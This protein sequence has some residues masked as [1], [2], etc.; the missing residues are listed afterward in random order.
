MR[1][2]RRLLCLV[3]FLA[4]ATLA[5]PAQTPHGPPPAHGLTLAAPGWDVRDSA[6][7]STISFGG[8]G[9]GR[10]RGSSH[11]RADYQPH[12]R[13]A[14]A[15]AYASA[16]PRP[17]P[18]AKRWPRAFRH[19]SVTLTNGGAKT[20]ESVRMDF[21]FKD[22]ATGAEVNR[23][24]HRSRKRLRPGETA[25]TRK[26]VMASARHRRGDGMALNVEVTEVVYA[27]GTAW[28]P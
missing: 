17:A 15:N 14:L 9:G 4:A 3:A 13:Q 16:Y 27:D 12:M 2:M 22:P 8:G 23:I 5:A 11:S 20:V 26:E 6:S 25:T 19:A 10:W 7:F 21:V 18:P 28:R 24:R 1:R